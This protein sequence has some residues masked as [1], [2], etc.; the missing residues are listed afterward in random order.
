MKR[1]MVSQERVEK[2]LEKFRQHF[3][4]RLKKKGYGAYA[5]SHEAYGI[6]AEEMHELMV[7]LHGNNKTKFVDEALD[8]AVACI[9]AAASLE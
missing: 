6:I 3:N 8:I 4:K 7:E 1:D 2:A 5:S 9:W